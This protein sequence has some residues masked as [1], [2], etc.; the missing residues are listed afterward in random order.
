[1]K[2]SLFIILAL[3]LF[4]ISVS[5]SKKEEGDN[6]AVKENIVE[7]QEGIDDLTAQRNKIKEKGCLVGVAY[8][9]ERD[10]GIEELGV[11]LNRQPYWSEYPMF[12]NISPENIIEEIG[13]EMYL[14]IPLEGVTTKVYRCKYDSTEGTYEKGEEFD[15]PKNGEPFFLQGNMFAP[16]FVVV[17][18]KNGK[19]VEFLPVA[20]TDKGKLIVEKELVYDI[21]P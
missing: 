14:I 5:C 1:M 21:M 19:K 9:G 10:P 6:G 8:L 15:I 17:A 20:D 3:L 18:E 12:F 7:V 11:F 4:V 2:K 13:G 16:S